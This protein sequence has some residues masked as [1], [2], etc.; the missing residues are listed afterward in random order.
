[1]IISSLYSMYLIGVPYYN[2]HVDI[3]ERLPRHWQLVVN[4][5]HCSIY[6]LLKTTQLWSKPSHD[7]GCA[8]GMMMFSNN[9]CS[10]PSANPLEPVQYYRT[11]PRI[12]KVL[13]IHLTNHHLHPCSKCS[14]LPSIVPLAWPRGNQAST[15]EPREPPSRARVD[16]PDHVYAAS[17]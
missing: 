2:T 15:C 3:F 9:I 14:S 17:S 10:L 11:W 5:M 7:P 1:M 4:F 8:A 12:S 13:L 16:L 6:Y